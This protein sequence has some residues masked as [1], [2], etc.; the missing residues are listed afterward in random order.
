[1]NIMAA[2]FST[3]C[4]QDLQAEIHPQFNNQLN[5]DQQTSFGIKLAKW[6]KMHKAATFM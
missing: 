2:S 5:G 6:K 3:R 1:M 4:I